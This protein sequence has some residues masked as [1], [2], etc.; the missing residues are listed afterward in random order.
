MSL[1]LVRAFVAEENCK[2]KLLI[3]TQVNLTVICCNQTTDILSF[4]KRNRKLFCNRPRHISLQR[5]EQK[6]R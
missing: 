1:S 5:T 4:G 6:L 2:K 3:L